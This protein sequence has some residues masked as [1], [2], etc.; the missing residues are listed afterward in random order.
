MDDDEKEDDMRSALSDAFDAAEDEDTEFDE[1]ETEA[2]DEE[3][4]SEDSEDEDEDEESEGEDEDEESD[5]EE[6]D[7]EESDD[8]DSSEEEEGEGEEDD[9]DG[10]DESGSDERSTTDRPPSSWDPEVREH[11]S[12]LPQEVRDEINRRERE[13]TQGLGVASQAREVASQWGNLVQPYIPIMQASGARN[14]YEAV[15]ALLKTAASLTMGTDVQKAQAMAGV[16]QQYG[17]NIDALDNALS[18]QAGATSPV[19]VQNMVN[20]HL[21]QWQDQQMQTE[22]N[23]RSEQIAN[24]IKAF[25]ADPTNEF[26][27][28]VKADMADL[29]DLADKRNDTL[30]LEDAYEKA[31]GMNTKI[32]RV[33]NQ[34][35]AAKKAKSN[36]KKVRAKK[37]AASSVKGKPGA[38]TSTKEE[39]ESISATL[40]RSWDQAEKR[41]VRV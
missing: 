28:D 5:D 37:K 10:D 27:E 4:D 15:D 32:Q 6:S 21:N 2:E 11:W 20:D 13:I 7:G 22:Q 18:G 14:P 26:Y 36:K 1:E 38:D 30:S 33:L 12:S 31:C 16:I 23:K 39:D 41:R 8:D 24:D 35:E 17:I 29:M 40:N 3:E 9:G 34:R 25:A 19:D